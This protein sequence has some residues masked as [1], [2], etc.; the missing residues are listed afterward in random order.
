MTGKSH[1]AIG[2]A[3]ALAVAAVGLSRNNVM[4][5]AT[6]LTTPFGSMLPDI[7]HPNSKLG[8]K[9]VE[10]AKKSKKAIV[11]VVAGYGAV[12]TIYGLVTAGTV[13]AVTSIASLAMY[14]VPALFVLRTLNSKKVKDKTE[15]FRKHRGILHTALAALSIA[16]G[17]KLSPILILET[18]L[19]GISIG[20][21]THLF[22][23][24]QTERGC[25]LLYPITK[26]NIR[27]PLYCKTGTRGETLMVALDIG[28]ILCL[29]YLLCLR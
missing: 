22:A 13:G 2:C 29:A 15:F 12:T 28:G 24:M 21:L 19:F 3:T 14:V 7:D 23:D 17:A 4:L 11:G 10:A 9:R 27:F 5:V 16:A 18:L 20:Y 1:Y 8:K 25:P 26:K 6:A